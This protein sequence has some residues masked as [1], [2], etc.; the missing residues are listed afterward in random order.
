MSYYPRALEVIRELYDAPSHEAERLRAEMDAMTSEER[1]YMMGWCDG[2]I[3]GF[4]QHR[5]DIADM[6]TEGKS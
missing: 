6:S 3:D 4:A 1:A 2:R 5:K